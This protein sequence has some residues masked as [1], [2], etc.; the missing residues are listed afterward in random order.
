M[1]YEE[2]GVYDGENEEEGKEA[3][4]RENLFFFADQDYFRSRRFEFMSAKNPGKGFVF[5]LFDPRDREDESG[6][7]T[8]DELDGN[9]YLS[10]YDSGHNLD[11][12]QHLNK[13]NNYR[14]LKNL[15]SMIE[16]V[17]PISNAELSGYEVVY[18]EGDACLANPDTRYKTFVRYLCDIDGESKIND[19]PKLIPTTGYDGVNECA[20]SFVWHSRF[21]CSV[22]QLNQ[23][24]IH[25]GFCGT[26][27]SAKVHIERK[28]GEQCVIDF[29]P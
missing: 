20:F 27:G 14:V 19:F 3:M 25:E 9:T 17:N 15:G 13:M 21:A 23:V 6:E 2:R 10:S 28:A 24:H 29:L 18:N 1:S 16:N 26:D 5:G 4:A 12:I 22:C 8:V 11:P 7:K